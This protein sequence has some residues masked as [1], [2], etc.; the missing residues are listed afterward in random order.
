[1]PTEVTIALRGRC[2]Y[3]CEYCVARNAEEPVSR[4]CLERLRAIYE[5]SRNALMVTALECGASEPAMHPQIREIMSLAAEYGIISMPTNN[6]IP[7]ERWLPTA[8]GPRLL[9]RAALHPRGEEHLP[10]FL[11]NLLRARA[12]G[13]RVMVIFVAHP[14]RFGKIGRYRDFFRQHQIPVWLT[15]FSG[16]FQG[17]AYPQSYTPEQIEFMQV[18]QNWW[19]TR[20]YPEIRCRDFSGIP[21]LA[22]WKSLFIDPDGNL[23]RCLYDPKVLPTPLSRAV[24]CRVGNCG[25]GLLLQELSIYDTGFINYW[26]ELAGQPLLPRDA[27]KPDERFSVQQARYWALMRRHGKI[28]PEPNRQAGGLQHLRN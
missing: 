7:P 2:N 15:L 18:D 26:R 3:R 25:C 21:C 10:R 12:Q 20:L 19:Y 1:M 28:A 14:G 11:E 9:I 17:R 6:S 16:S 22:G 27:L 8:V 23:R 4:H 13:A 5:A 24:P